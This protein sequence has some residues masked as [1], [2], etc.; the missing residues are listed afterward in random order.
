[1]EAVE[2]RVGDIVR[3]VPGNLYAITDEF[4]VGVIVEAYPDVQKERNLRA[5]WGQKIVIRHVDGPDDGI[6]EV[7]TMIKDQ[8]AFQLEFSSMDS[9]EFSFGDLY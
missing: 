8:P 7:F 6:F 3:G 9:I 5:R 2:F 1:M 4:F